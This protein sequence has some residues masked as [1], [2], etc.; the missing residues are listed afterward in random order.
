MKLVSVRDV[1]NKLSQYLKKAKEEDV[2]ITRN[3]HPTAVLHAFEDEEELE[4]YLLEHDPNF[5]RKIEARWDRY[6]KGG[7]IPFARL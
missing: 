1:K 2:V 5:I 4:D 6:V 3:G 7:S